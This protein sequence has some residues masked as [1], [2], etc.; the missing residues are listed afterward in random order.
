MRDAA[1]LIEPAQ[2]ELDGDADGALA[3]YMGL[4]PLE[5]LVA[6]LDVLIGLLGYGAYSLAERLEQLDAY[7]EAYPELFARE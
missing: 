6:K 4:T 1:V 7:V 3:D 5:E 2:I